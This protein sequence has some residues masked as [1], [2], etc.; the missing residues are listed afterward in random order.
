MKLEYPIERRKSRAVK[1]GDVII[2]GGFPV[3]VQSMTNTDT[4]DIEATVAQ[5][6]QLF[7]AGAHIVRMSV[8]N[9]AAAKCLPE[10]RRPPWRRVLRQTVESHTHQY[11]LLQTLACGT[12]T[13]HTHHT[14]GH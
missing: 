9:D 5:A 7:D 14:L 13:S 4:R 11:R 10:I 2:G 1:I 3:A 12:G 8:L 6:Q